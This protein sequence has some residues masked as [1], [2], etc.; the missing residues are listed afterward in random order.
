M[1]IFRNKRWG[2]GKKHNLMGIFNNKLIKFSR[3]LSRK[4]K[5]FKLRQVKILKLNVKIKKKKEFR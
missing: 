1:L 2:L 3:K 5:I 4:M